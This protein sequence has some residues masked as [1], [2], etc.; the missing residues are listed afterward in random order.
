ME[1]ARIVLNTRWLD[2]SNT[3]IDIS[4]EV[5]SAAESQLSEV[6]TRVT[7]E[8]AKRIIF[9]FTELD[10]MNSSGIGFLVTLLIRA[11][12]QGQQLMAFG[13]NKHYNHIFE[14]TRLNEAIEICPNELDIL[15]VIKNHEAGQVVK[16]PSA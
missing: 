4:G 8:G 2:A 13:L 12:R 15:D 5:T 16:K 10:Y 1:Q 14:L 6:Y 9:N 3:I 7:S 11:Q